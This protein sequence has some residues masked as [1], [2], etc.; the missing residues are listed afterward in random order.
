MYFSDAW[1]RL[2]VAIT[3]EI[4]HRKHGFLRAG[5]LGSI[6]LSLYILVLELILGVISLPIYMQ[7][8]HRHDPSLFN[9]AG[10]SFRLYRMR[11]RAAAVGITTIALLSLATFWY[12]N[13]I[14]AA[15]LTWDGG[16]STANWNDCLNWTTDTCPG[17]S[18]DVI[19]DSTTTTD[20]TIDGSFGGTVASVTI[21]SGYTGTIT[22]A[23]SLTV[24]GS[25]SQSD[26]IFIGNTEA[27]D[28]NGNFTLSAGTVTSTSGVLSV[29]GDFTISSGATFNHASG[30]LQLDASC[31]CSENFN[32]DSTL[33]LN[34]LTFDR[35]SSGWVYTLGAGDEVTVMGTLSFLDGGFNSADDDAKIIINPDIASTSIVFGANFDGSNG[36]VQI[37]TSTASKTW[38]LAGGGFVP[39]LINHGSGVTIGTASSTSATTMSELTMYDGT[40]DFRNLPLTISQGIV[41]TSGTLYGGANNTKT[42]TLN[43][44]AATTVTFTGGIW[45]HG[46]AT[47]T[48]SGNLS[49]ATGTYNPS[50]GPLEIGGN[51]TLSSGIFNATS[52]TLYVGGNLTVS[53]P[54]TWTHNSGTLY[55]DNQCLCNRTINVSNEL[56]LYNLT[57]NG[58]WSQQLAAGD[59]LFASGTVSFTNGGYISND[60]GAEIVVDPDDADVNVVFASTFD[61][62]TG[63]L[64]IVTSTASH[65]WNLQGGGSF[66]HIINHAS[67]VTIGTE[68]SAST[69]TAS[70]LTLYD[71]TFD[72]RNLPLNVTQ[73][74]DMTSGTLYGAN[75][76]NTLAFSSTASDT[77]VVSGGM[78]YGGSGTTSIFQN[79][80]FT[81]ATYIGGGGALDSNGNVTLTSGSFTA[82]SGTMYIAGNFTP[83]SALT[84]AHS[85]G[86][87]YFDN[88]CYCNR[89]INLPTTLDVNNVTINGFWTQNIGSGDTL[90]VYGLL[91]LVDGA[92][93]VADIS[94]R[95]DVYQASTYDGGSATITFNGSGSQRFIGG[96]TASVGWLNDVVINKTTGTLTLGGL[97]RET[98]DWTYTLGTV[99]PATSSVYF[100]YG[101]N[102]D[103][104]NASSTRMS[105]NDVHFNGGTVSLTGDI[106]VDGDLYLDGEVGVLNGNAN[107]VYLAGDWIKTAGGFTHGNGGV[108][109][110]GSS[111]TIIGTATFYNFTKSTSTADTLTFPSSV[112]NTFNGTLT[113]AGASG[114]LLSLRA[115]TPGSETR[116]KPN[117]SRSVT[118]LDV[119]DNNNVSDTTID[120][121]DG[122][123]TDSGNNTNWDFGNSAPTITNYSLTPLTDAS[124][125]VSISLDIDDAD[126]NATQLRMEYRSGACS[127]TGLTSTTLSSTFTATYGQGSITFDNSATYQLQNITTAS[128]TNTLA[129]AWQSATDEA[130]GD[131]SYCVFATAYDGST[132]STVASSTVTLD[133]VD[134]TAPGSLTLSSVSSGAIL[135]AFGATTTDT[136]F[137]EYIIYYTLGSSGV[138]QSDTAFSSSSDSN[139]GSVTYG[140]ASTTTISGLNVNAQYVLNIWA[141]D[142]Y[143]NSSTA[144]TELVVFSGAA[145]PSSI[146]GSANSASAVTISW[147]AN[148]NPAGTEFY[149]EDTSDTSRN[150]GWT[151][152]TSYTFS[153]LSPNTSYRF[154]VR[155]R[156]TDG[157]AT[158]F[159]TMSDTVRTDSGG[160]VIIVTTGGGDGDSGDGGGDDSDGGDDGDEGGDDGDD[161][162]DDADDADD[163]EDTSDDGDDN[164]DDGGDSEGETEGNDD[165]DSDDGDDGDNSGDGGSV[166][167]TTG[168]GDGDSGDSGGDGEGDGDGSDDGDTRGETEGGDDGDDGDD[169]GTI[170]STGGGDGERRQENAIISTT[171]RRSE[172]TEPV[173][174]R[175]PIVERA[176][177]AVQET[178]EVVERAVAVVEEIADDPQVEEVAEDIVSPVTATVVTASLAA[179]IS[180]AAAGFLEYFLL[181]PFMFLSTRKRKAWG[182]VYNSLNKLPIDLVVV[183]LLDWKT[184][185]VVQTRVTD[186]EGRYMFF[187]PKGEYRINVQ[188]TGFIFPSKNMHE[189]Q[190]DGER[191]DLYYGD[192]IVVEQD[193][194]PI[195]P[196]IPIDPRSSTKTPRRL[197]MN[198]YVHRAQY[199][200]AGL[201]IGATGLSMYVAPS[202]KTLAFFLLQVI[203]SYGFYAYFKLRQPKQ[204]ATVRNAITGEPIQHA[205]VQLFAK[206]YDK[207]VESHVTDKQGRYAFLVGQNTYYAVVHRP[208]YQRQRTADVEVTENKQTIF[209]VDMLLRPETQ[210]KEKQEHGAFHTLSDQ[211][212]K[213]ILDEHTWHVPEGKKRQEQQTPTFH[214]EDHD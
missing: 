106:N 77:V 59:Q 141:Y 48:L 168:G 98:G 110:D 86:T 85:S 25:W 109:M 105:F 44:T 128:G 31:L 67:G 19:F 7:K 212:K 52:N 89:T 184:K 49:F 81:T 76:G 10:F 55:F 171:P 172:R 90:I 119:Q 123:S 213:E 75:T 97:I 118:Y 164:G 122:T 160:S 30:T 209:R 20:A 150:S 94:A 12:G 91:N 46:N 28:V 93:G 126:D 151:T 188:K 114:Q 5:I 121:T 74:L 211:E 88:N 147:S 73:G 53:S 108:I 18:D 3:R 197:I 103:G 169:G 157:T 35:A 13:F 8:L 95:G 153:S 65:T 132:T 148:G 206:P 130:A 66:G 68:T 205:V 185:K 127:Y 158:A 137:Q 32:I 63:N 175:S 186:E 34:N 87:L 107:D 15:T 139:L 101:L 23:R 129:I 62:G 143:G 50:G 134:P 183:R 92:F 176:R 124:G 78:W 27:I 178:V 207:L 14:Q 142:T 36:N 214:P 38:N 104:E 144:A 155:A 191:F 161:D 33:T 202:I 45:N 152:A 140:G 198:R 181:Q 82:T 173:R 1:V 196:N 70:E 174:E 112:S 41:M 182:I 16:G 47:T 80:T 99:D 187:A 111:Q 208:G 79:F 180:T 83:G 2:V 102:L 58:S 190:M 21:S 194:T 84:W 201:G 117:G 9:N 193:G 136:N 100:S 203:I 24:G 116:I 146:S 195:A 170:I 6:L 29:N 4:H 189:V 125:D 149:V 54:V 69:A 40:A 115:S 72:L 51:L 135:P 71:G 11:R 200:F 113:L 26:G 60:D 167:I 145:L 156:N 133:N 163:G 61:G 138:T 179:P 204:W 39:H 22:Q 162:N 57:F 42:L 159:V 192:K 131:G 37:V 165:D 56:R 210:A 96:A 120:A 166:I 64:R 154:R 17:A 43:S 177:S 199:M